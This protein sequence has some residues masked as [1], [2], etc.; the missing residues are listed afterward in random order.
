MKSW[1]EK[2]LEEVEKQRQLDEIHQKPEVKKIFVI[3]EI[4]LTIDW[5]SNILFFGVIALGLWT[6]NIGKVADLT[7]MIFILLD[8]VGGYFVAAAFIVLK[9]VL[10]RF[11]KHYRAKLQVLE[12]AG[13]IE[14][15]K[16]K[17][18]GTYVEGPKPSLFYR[19]YRAT[20]T[21]ITIIVFTASMISLC[22]FL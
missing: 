1:R 7:A 22:R 21:W 17:E 19:I 3:C 11:K 6:N 13:L 18:D 9:L 10:D 14:I 2:G 12:D 5:I 20:R 4:F 16:A 8:A 15:K